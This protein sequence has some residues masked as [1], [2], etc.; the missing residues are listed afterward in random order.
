MQNFL[1]NKKRGRGGRHKH[2]EQDYQSNKLSDW[3]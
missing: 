1:T 3:S 2:T